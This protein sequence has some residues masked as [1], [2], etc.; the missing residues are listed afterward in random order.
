[1]L[2]TELIERWRKS[3]RLA[4]ASIVVLMPLYLGL[5]ALF[6]KPGRVAVFAAHGVALYEGRSMAGAVI[7]LHPVDEREPDFPLPQATVSADDSYVVGTYGRDDGA[8]AGEY[9]VTVQWFAKLTNPENDD[10]RLPPNLL[11]QQYA[12]ADTSG[13]SVRIEEGDNTLPALELRR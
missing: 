9:R 11:P 5:S 8:P 7:F 2:V 13:L 12:R 10:G 3:F 4:V 6:A 1:M